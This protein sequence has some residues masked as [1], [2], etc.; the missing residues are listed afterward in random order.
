MYRKRGLGLDVC[1]ANPTKRSEEG[2]I[3]NPSEI[4]SIDKLKGRGNHIPAPFVCR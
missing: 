3:T 2:T 4:L 1:A